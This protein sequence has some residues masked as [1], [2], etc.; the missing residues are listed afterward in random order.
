MLTDT[1]E[2]IRARLR[3]C[4]ADTRDVLMPLAI[5]LHNELRNRPGVMGWVYA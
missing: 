3:T 4:D 2:G 5:A 1:L